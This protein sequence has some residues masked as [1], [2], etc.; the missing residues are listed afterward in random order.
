VSFH[1]NLFLGCDS[2]LVHMAVDVKDKG[3]PGAFY[4]ALAR[5]TRTILRLAEVVPALMGSSLFNLYR[6]R[7]S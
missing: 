2:E 3:H 5:D 1:R 4:V 6:Q 7:V